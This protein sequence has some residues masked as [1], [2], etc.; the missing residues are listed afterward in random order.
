MLTSHSVEVT[1]DQSS[2]VTSYLISYTTTASSTSVT[3]N[4][5]STTSYTLTNLEQNT[6]YIIT[7]QAKSSDNKLSIKNN[8]ISVTTYVDGKIRMHN[9]YH[10]R[11][12]G[13]GDNK[14][15]MSQIIPNIPKPRTHK[16]PYWSQT[17]HTV[18]TA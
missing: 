8:E 4:D 16:W 7:V 13:M 2:D 1:W 18:P 11:E 10:I 9:Y 3:V 6:Q 12:L 15:S 5:G 17:M 14:Y